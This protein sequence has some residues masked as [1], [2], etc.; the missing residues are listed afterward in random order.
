MSMEII[1]FQHN[2]V[3]WKYKVAQN[4]NNRLKN[5]G[6]KQSEEKYIKI[7]SSKRRCKVNA[8]CYYVLAELPGF[9]R[10]SRSIIIH[11]LEAVFPQFNM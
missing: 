6:N 8:S 3:V 4:N 1:I 7:V 9:A 2:V 10:D 5:E 11:V